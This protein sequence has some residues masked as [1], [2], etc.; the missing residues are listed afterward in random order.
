MKNAKVYVGDHPINDVEEEVSGQFVER[1]GEL[2]YQIAGFDRM[3]PFLMSIVSDADHWMFIS[4]TGALTA[5]RKNAHS[6]LFPYYTEDKIH[7][8]RDLTGSKTILLVDLDGQKKLWEPFSDRFAGA[9]QIKRNLYKHLAGNKIVF[10][11]INLDLGLTFTYAWSNS[12][13]YG[14]VKHATILNTGSGNASIEVLDGIQ[15][16]L[17][18]GADEY[19]QTNYSRLVDAYKK[20]ELE[21]GDGLGIFRLSSLVVDRPVPSES[22]RATTVWIAGIEPTS[23]LLSSKQLDAFRKGERLQ[24]EKDVRAERGA[25]FVLTTL[26]LTP[27]SQEQW[28]LVA[29][30]NQGMEDI[31]S[32]KRELNRR[33][34]LTRALVEDIQK[35]TDN[36]RRIVASADGLQRTADR[37]VN[38]RHYANVLFNVMRGGIFHDNGTISRLEL[39]QFVAQRNSKV[40]NRH[41]GFFAGLADEN[42]VG[43]LIT[44]AANTGDAQL[45]RL[46]YEFLPLTFSRRHGD[47]SR[48]WNKFSIDTRNADGSVKLSYEGNWR[49]IFQN[50]EALARSFP[51]YLEGMICKFVNASTPDGYNPYRISSAGIDW[52]VIEPDDPW[53][54]IGYWGDHQA[55]YLLKLLEQAKD[56]HPDT[57]KQFLTRDI[58]SYANVPYRIASYKQ[59]LEDPHNTI[60]YD[61]AEETL[62]AQRSDAV[63]A[64]GKL[65]WD[66]DESVYLVNLTEKLLVLVLAKLSNFIPGGGIWMNTQ[67]PEWNDANNALVGY[68]VSM[69]TLY[70]LQR[71]VNFMTGLFEEVAGRSITVSA[72]VGRMFADIS[73]SFQQFKS[74]LDQSP[75][76]STRKQILDELGE[77]GSTFREAVYAN[78]FSGEK[79]RLTGSEIVSFFQDAR[80]FF[81]QTIDA[82]RRQDG[83]YHAYN[84]MESQDE[85]IKVSYLYE[86]LEGQVAALSTGTLAPSV[87]VEVLDALKSSSMYRSDQYSYM[88]YP[89]RQLPRFVDKNNVAAHRLGKLALL[90]KLTTNGNHSLFVKNEEG[91]YHF[92]GNITNN[93]DVEA[94][95]SRLQ[96]AGYA[97]EVEEARPVIMNIFETLF[98]HRSYTGRSGTFFGYEGLGS[99]YWH[100]VSKLVLAIQEVYFDA[101]RTNASPEIIGR[102]VEAYYETRAGIGLNKSPEL[103]G[104]FPFDP[105]SHTP[106]NMGVQQPGL[107]GQVKEDIMSRWG[108]LGVLVRNGCIHFEPHL[109]RESEFLSTPASFDY[110]DLSGS[111]RRLSLD[112]GMLSFT[113]C[114]VPVIYQLSGNVGGR[115]IFQNGET[116]TL[117]TNVL[118]RGVSESIF[119]RQ[120][121]IEQIVIKVTL[122]R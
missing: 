29:E 49:D 20:N 24:T 102:L 93:E 23:F 95:L 103:Y 58:F 113:I 61:E 99:I 14:F 38:A 16:L 50:W 72:E 118:D 94:V 79:T 9:Y 54:N 12:D 10:E 76:N 41:N 56:H 105:Y 69:V 35:G 37:M 84:L 81:E 36:L 19:L 28:Y 80:A 108:E 66:K 57:L 51:D 3:R 13:R 82:N 101:C 15:N 52:E 71:Y 87:A 30:V 46:C 70:Y 40:A 75:T 27:G 97:R 115:I 11:E 60:T 114:Q 74:T 48:P 68:G 59:L 7:D 25:F 104:A 63:G 91:A 86:M 116:V 122:E 78:G 110:F 55:I 2:Y 64:D 73:K 47:P 120:G 39:R 31:V 53:S 34:A 1:D 92:D 85:E 4:S 98:D 119:A 88:L 111:A 32:L 67:R 107:T 100:M 21:V 96:A 26:N 112:A 89:D 33:P 17:P 44:K 8:S 117:E 42:S 77:A 90:D 121:E 18:S 6:S 45:E 109:L 65:I 62:I 5:G 43:E 83:L 22:L 106:G